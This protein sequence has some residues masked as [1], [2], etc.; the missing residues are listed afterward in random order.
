MLRVRD[1][2]MSLFSF[3]VNQNR[4]SKREGVDC[5]LENMMKDTVLFWLLPWEAIPPSYSQYLLRGS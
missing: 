1:S 5:R 3:A 4:N 2:H